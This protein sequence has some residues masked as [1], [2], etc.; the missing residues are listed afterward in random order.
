VSTIPTYD[1]LAAGLRLRCARGATFRVRVQFQD[2]QGDPVNLSTK[3]ITGGVIGGTDPQ[4]DMAEST[5]ATGLLVLL[6][7]DEQTQALAE[8]EYSYKVWWASG[9]EKKPILGGKFNV[10]PEHFGNLAATA[11]PIVLTLYQ[12]GG[13]IYLTLL[14]TDFSAGGGDGGYDH[15]QSSPSATWT[16]NHNLGYR[17][18]V[19]LLSA[20][21]VEMIAEIV[22]TSANQVVATFKQ[23]VAGRA[24]LA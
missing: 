17:P 6:L 2:E 19:S 16:I 11:D 12:E 3:T 5:L 23:A 20:G 4:F 1:V 18:A 22:H 21:G 13:A 10:L 14:N 15:V 7:T 8:A 24:R 9:G